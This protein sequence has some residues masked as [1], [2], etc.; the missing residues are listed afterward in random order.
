MKWLTFPELSARADQYD[1]RV[2]ETPDI[3]RFCS[4]T[5]WIISAAEA[6]IGDP[7]PFI[8]ET[9]DGF[10]AMMLMDIADGMRAAVP[11]EIGW[12]LAA[13][14]AGP[15]PEA[16]TEQLARM[17]SERHEEVE[18]VIVSGVPANGAWAHQLVKRYISTQR[19]GLGQTC[20]RRMASLKG[21]FDGFMNRRSPNFRAKL[22]RAERKALAAGLQYTYY[23]ADPDGLLF[24]RIMAIESE[25]W[26]GRLGE[27][28]NQS[29]SAEFYRKMTARLHEN[30]DLRIVMTHLEGQDIGFVFGG[31]F[32]GVYRGLQM[33]YRADFSQLEV[34]N[35]GQRMMLK[36]MIDEGIETYDLG[37]DM[38]YK[39]RWAEQSFETQMFVIMPAH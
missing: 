34:G 7:E 5:P 37:T 2:A 29:P 38:P 23:R 4:T 22:R 15:N 30:G 24:H 26:K 12:G 6:L 21:G 8:T 16:L 25:S 14:F 18:A 19:I 17:W 28:F 1:A 27:G 39:T 32:Q 10:V 31:V 13:P 9:A 3:D 20:I 11:L 36:H 35:L 33:S